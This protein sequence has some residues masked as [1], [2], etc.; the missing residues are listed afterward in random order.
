MAKQRLAKPKALGEAQLLMSVH[1]H[2]CQIA[3][4]WHKQTEPGKVMVRATVKQKQRG[5][6]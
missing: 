3:D 2:N 6:A 5:G 1:R 4:R